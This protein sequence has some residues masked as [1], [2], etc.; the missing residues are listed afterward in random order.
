MLVVKNDNLF[1]EVKI[2]SPNSFE[3]SRGF[4]SEI[5]NKKNFEV[6][7]LNLNFVQDNLS[8]TKNKM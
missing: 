7:C 8:F 3:D 1:H 6:N 2:I 5:Y 4:F